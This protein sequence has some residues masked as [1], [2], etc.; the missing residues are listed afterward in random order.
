MWLDWLAN[1][2]KEKHMRNSVE[3]SIHLGQRMTTPDGIASMAGFLLS[4]R[5][6]AYDWQMDACE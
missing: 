4:G 2:E 3:K 1:F 6:G 5:P